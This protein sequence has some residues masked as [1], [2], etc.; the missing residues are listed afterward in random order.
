MHINDL[1][2]PTLLVDQDVLDANIQR[3]ANYC[4]QHGIHL[5]AHVKS[6]KSPMIAYKQVAAGACGIVC[7]K[8][9]EAEIF[10]DAG[11][12]DILI[13]NNIVGQEKLDCLMRLAERISIRVTVD[14]LVVAEGIS[15][16]AKSAGH[17][18]PILIE[19]DTCGKRCGTQTPQAT[20]ELGK[21]LTDLPQ[22][23]LAGLMTS[24]TS[25]SCRPYLL[26]TLDRFEAAEIP[27][28]IVSGGEML[29]AFQTHK[30]PEITE[31]HVGTYVFYDLSHVYCGVCRLVDCALTVLT[32]VVSTPTSDR[33]I[34]DAGAKTFTMNSRAH[35]KS[36]HNRVY[37]VI[38]N[39]PDVVISHLSEEHGHLNTAN[40]TY[41]FRVG[42]KVQAIPIDSWATVSI[43]DT[44]A[45][46]RGSRV[47]E[48]LPI[49]A[50]G[51]TK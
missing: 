20:V 4:K 21:Q 9:S 16:A 47:L 27:I 44:F 36:P 15:Q 35:P 18:I 23:E 11:F 39:Y 24:C 42:E 30:I 26:D 7:Q 43:N 51:Q 17:H 38:K 25:P 33:V 41:R 40:T 32:T 45:L 6:H 31:L 12:N 2:T 14:S 50:R 3:M 34:L 8:L 28:P 5:R 1:Q 37:G 49:T 19:M 10:A 48:I 13:P 22:V 46:V 29:H